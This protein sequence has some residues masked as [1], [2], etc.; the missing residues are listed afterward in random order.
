MTRGWRANGGAVLSC[1]AMLILPI[2]RSWMVSQ[3]A[4]RVYL[5]CAILTIALIV[6]WVALNLMLQGLLPMKAMIVLEVVL[7]PEVFGTAL[8][9]VAMFYFWFGFDP[10][11]WLVRAIWIVLLYCLAP[12]SPALYYFFVYRKVARS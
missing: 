11:P 12:F 3:T 9:W 6:T 4:R 5:V 2:S 10:S 1:A 7:I 8:L